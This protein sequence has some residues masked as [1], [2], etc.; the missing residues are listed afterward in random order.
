M[1]KG[2]RIS[3]KHGL[4]PCIPICIFCGQEKKEI[5]L[6]GKLK[7]DVEAPMY[8]VI[9]YE[10][11]ENCRAN[12]SM[13]VALL[14]VSET[15]LKGGM[16]PLAVKDGKDIY[17]TGQ[18]FVMTQDA[19]KQIFDMDMEKGQA[20]MIEDSA[21]DSFLSDLKDQGILDENGNVRMKGK[22]PC[23]PS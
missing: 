18:Y 4:N 12:W 19:V 16:P 5:A 9:D 13:G 1:S 11:C 22:R 15:P 6:M 8:A 2:I 23:A 7:D 20:V 14:R 10:P 21:F 17:P 3:P